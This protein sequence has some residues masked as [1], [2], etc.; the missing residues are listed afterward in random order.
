MHDTALKSGELFA[1]YYGSVNKIVV[2]I[3]GKDVNGSLRVYFENMGMKYICVDI[4]SHPSVDIVIKPG[5]KLP[6]DN[7][8]VD[9]IVS[10][11]CFEHDPCFWIT[12]K[13]MTRITKLGGFIYVNAPSNGSYHC[14]PG[15]NW[16]FYSDAG[17]ALSYWSCFKY[18]NEEIF[19]VKVVETFH[20]LPKTGEWL[21]FVCIWER[22]NEIQ[23][24]II[25][26]S[27]IYE[28]KGIL[29]T[30]LNN[31]NFTTIKKVQQL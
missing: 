25:V 24:D 8:S 17:Q 5:D 18:S 31:D 6:F 26:S 10:T 9:L 16:R 27:N 23:T 20:I 29:E 13:D 1:H 15:D 30:K 12:F 4:E 7:G 21:D 14:H 2:D 19:P 28:N 11:S 22:V 3:G